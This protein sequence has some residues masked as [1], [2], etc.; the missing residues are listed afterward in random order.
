MIGA[1]A[2]QVDF[3][4][5]EEVAV[6]GRTAGDGVFF[7]EPFGPFRYQVAEVDNFDVGQRPVAFDMGR[8]DH[9]A[10]DDPALDHDIRLY[11]F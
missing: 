2:D 4:I 5:G 8:C 11:L 7:S 1:D 10:A 6:V 3:G 9:S